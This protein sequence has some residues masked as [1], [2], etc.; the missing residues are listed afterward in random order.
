MFLKIRLGWGGSLLSNFKLKI[1]K[2][3]GEI[4]L[5]NGDAVGRNDHIGTN[6]KVG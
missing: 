4:L 6:K 3:E 2:N 5:A 1:N